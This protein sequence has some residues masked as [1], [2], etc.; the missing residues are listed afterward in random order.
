MGGEAKGLIEIAGKPMIRY[1]IDRFSDQCQQLVINAN[2]NLLYYE[3]LGYPVIRDSMPGY[4]GPLAGML[5]GM[6][7]AK[8]QFVLFVPCDAPNLPDELPERLLTAIQDKIDISVAGLGTR[9]QPVI[10]LC[11]TSLVQSLEDAL[12]KGV[13]KTGEWIASQSH[14]IVDFSDRQSDFDNINTM[15]ELNSLQTTLKNDRKRSDRK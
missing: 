5:S 11:R 6:Q 7:Y 3:Q 1:I 14:V 9:M 8:T 13:R 2:E 10:A 15:E 4:Q 12:K